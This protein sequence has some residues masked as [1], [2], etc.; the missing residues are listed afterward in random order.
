[1][2]KIDPDFNS[3]DIELFQKLDLV[4]DVFISTYNKIG[5]SIEKMTEPINSEIKRWLIKS[6]TWSKYE[7]NP[8]N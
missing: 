8:E 7:P 4:V 6:N 3:L 2:K 1:M 5:A